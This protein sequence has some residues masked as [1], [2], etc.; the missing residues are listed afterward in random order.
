[1]GMRPPPHRCALKYLLWF[2]LAPK[3]VPTIR[4]VAV[5]DDDSFVHVG[6]LETDL[7]GG[8]RARPPLRLAPQDGVERRVVLT[9][10]LRVEAGD[11]VP[12]EGEPKCTYVLSP[13]SSDRGYEETWKLSESNG[14]VIIRNLDWPGAYTVGWS[15]RPIARYTSVYVGYGVKYSP[16][17]Y[18]P[19]MPANLMTEFLMDGAA[20]QEAPDPLDP[21]PEPEEEEAE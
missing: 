7:E 9:E 8:G 12:W 14:A 15:K 3:L 21:P 17:V 13:L 6:R 16:T 4:F 10:R 1:M 18:T 2:E 20:F 11:E 5:A 19:P